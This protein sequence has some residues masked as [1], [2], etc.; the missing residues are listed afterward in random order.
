MPHKV[1]ALL[2]AV[3]LVVTPVVQAQVGRSDSAEKTRAKVEELGTR[4]KVELKLVD[5]TKYK[6]RINSFDRTSVT[7][8]DD[9][10]P[11]THTFTYAEITSIKKSAS[12][13]PLTWG[14]IG[15]AAAAAIIV[16]VTVIK[17]VVCDGGAGC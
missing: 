11:G 1:F 16:G 5:G 8:E 17:P 9:K 10:K 6:G 2:I 14:L 3:A 4:S 15:G 12:V 7:I 13:S